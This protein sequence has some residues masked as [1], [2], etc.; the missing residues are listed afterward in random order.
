MLQTSKEI[1]KLLPLVD[2]LWSRK[3]IEGG[4]RVNLLRAE[5]GYGS[6]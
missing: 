6:G 4:A 3:S 1:G 2:L 5:H